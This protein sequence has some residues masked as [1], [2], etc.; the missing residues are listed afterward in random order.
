MSR[1]FLFLVSKGDSD[2]VELD[3]VWNHGIVLYAA[4]FIDGVLGMCGQHAPTP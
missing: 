1:K 3:C 4:G 2:S